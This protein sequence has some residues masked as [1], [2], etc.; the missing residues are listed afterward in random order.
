MRR[1]EYDFLNKKGP[2]I[3]FQE[4]T[5]DEAL[6]ENCRMQFHLRMGFGATIGQISNTEE[7]TRV[8]REWDTINDLRK[9]I[10]EGFAQ[11]REKYSGS[12]V[13]RFY[14]AV[15]QLEQALLDMTTE[16][17]LTSDNRLLRTIGQR[18]QQEGPNKCQEQKSSTLPPT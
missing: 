15:E 11:Q 2:R 13:E 17:M 8:Q 7:R 9:H 5:K 6:E 4:E 18:I 3:E 16:E 1:V 14:S 10:N 12:L